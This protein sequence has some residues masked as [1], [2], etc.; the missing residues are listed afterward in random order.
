MKKFLTEK[1]WLVLSALAAVLVV[2]LVV[3][4][5]ALAGNGEKEPNPTEG[6][7]NVG[8]STGTTGS[9][10]N[11]VTEPSGNTDDPSDVTE[12]TGT[13]ENPAKPENPEFPDDYV[14]PSEP[15]EDD[16]D[17]EVVVP[18][19]ED[20]EGDGPNPGDTGT[21]GDLTFSGGSYV[22]NPGD[23]DETIVDPNPTNPTPTP[24]PEPEPEPEPEYDFTGIT[25]GNI[26]YEQWSSWD[27]EKRQAF[28]NSIDLASATLDEKYN[29]NCATQ[30]Q[31]GYDCGYEN[32]YCVT[33]SGHNRLVEYMEEGCSY[34]GE[35]DCVSF[36]SRDNRGITRCWVDDCPM[37]HNNCEVCG[38]PE[39][40]YEVES[41]EV[42]C[43]KYLVD[44][45]CRDCGESVK[46]NEC[47]HCIKP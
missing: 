38:L 20:E 26:T 30:F 6:T 11:E 32:H 14:E 2:A 1:K 13:P 12:P 41:G 37:Y 28:R 40:D 15:D 19:A 5:F 10:G 21:S 39:V 4:I 27:Y 36:Y 35:H 3:G 7:S 25:V 45:I 16:T 29:Y 18:P 31:G 34:C 17:E 44:T 46:A 43:K 8:D 42:Y 23:D 24:D 33:E 22:G 9:N 47:H